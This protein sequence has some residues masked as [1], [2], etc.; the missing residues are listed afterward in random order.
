MYMRRIVT[1]CR[2]GLCWHFLKLVVFSDR[3]CTSML[4]LHRLSG[5]HSG[6]DSRALTVV[7]T[8]LQL[9]PTAHRHS[10]GRQLV[11]ILRR[12]DTSSML[13]GYCALVTEFD[14]FNP[15]AGPGASRTAAKVRFLR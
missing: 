12:S 10:K 11:S 8:V 2:F 4:P 9:S 15:S 6:P 7:D 3:L 5:R 13:L 1:L 14:V